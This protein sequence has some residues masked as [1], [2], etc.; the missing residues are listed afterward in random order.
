MGCLLPYPTAVLFLRGI[1]ATRVVTAGD[2]GTGK[3][4]EAGCGCEYRLSQPL[5]EELQRHTTASLS[6][7][8]EG[9]QRRGSDEGA[10][11]KGQ[12]LL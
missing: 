4:E 11:A 2:L 10:Q 1:G 3:G 7:A 6:L 12:R 9:L 5:R 8:S